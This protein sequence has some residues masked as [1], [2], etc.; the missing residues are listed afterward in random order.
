MKL[1]FLGQTY[2]SRQKQ[3]TTI[4]SELTGCYRGQR[5]ALRSPAIDLSSEPQA[6]YTSVTVRK[7]RGV[8]YI[9]QRNYPA[10]PN[11]KEVCHS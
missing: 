4:K 1:S 5:Y 11:K 8:S 10:Q 7:Y 3:I 6:S 2:S 9:V